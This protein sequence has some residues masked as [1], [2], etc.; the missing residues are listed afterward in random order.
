MKGGHLMFNTAHEAIEYIEKQIHKSSLSAYQK[1]LKQHHISTNGL[2]FI[3][4]TGTNGKGSTV[5]YLRSLLNQAGYKVGTFT[6][7]Y[8]VSYHDRICIDQIPISDEALLEIMNEHY[9]WIVHEQLSK[10]EI[11]VLIMLIYF[12]HQHVDYAIVE[13]GIGGRY[14]KTN[15][16]DSCLSLIS[17]IGHDHIPSLGNTLEDIAY[18]KAGIIKENTAVITTVTQP[19][20]LE[21]IKKEATL[22]QAQVIECHP[23]IVTGYPIM[24]EYRGIQL[25]MDQAALYQVSN[26][27]LA[28]EALF[29]LNVKLTDQ[30]IENAINETS[31][32]G[33]FEKI[34][35]H[36]RS[37]YIDGAHNIDGIHALQKTIDAF[38]QK[39]III[40]FSALRDKDYE[41]MI[42]EL[43][44][45]YTVFLTVF[46]DERKVSLD[47]LKVYT[48][49]FS[50]FEEALTEALLTDQMIVVTGSL[51]FI[52]DVRR[53]LLL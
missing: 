6:S 8:L 46:L 40:I 21:V 7:P 49:V 34:E 3:H 1:I 5:N 23:P 53:K 48:H 51:H 12:E 25:R 14:D 19:S 47:D 43:E 45:H 9:D 18:Q 37:I 11:D 20:C 27:C 32:P 31:W 41:K 10:F 30:Q 33:R 42:A 44:K 28:I 38:K 16:I 36:G 15:V 24:F 26:A 17:N 29:Y 4:V 52:S 22:K 2:K 50:S 13:V 39:D 35:Y